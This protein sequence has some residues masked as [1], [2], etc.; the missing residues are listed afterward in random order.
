TTDG[1]TAS[2]RNAVTHGLSAR[3]VLIEGE[4]PEEYEAFKSD[5]YAHFLPRNEYARSL[6]ELLADAMWRLRR[7]SRI[8]ALLL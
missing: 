4:Q 8:E 6:V 3:T 1:K 2:S 5:L 7:I